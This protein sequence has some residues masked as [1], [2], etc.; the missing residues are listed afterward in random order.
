MEVYGQLLNLEKIELNTWLNFS[1]IA[2]DPIS[3]ERISD[4]VN[5]C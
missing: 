3:D 5:I 1:E 4:K 2:L